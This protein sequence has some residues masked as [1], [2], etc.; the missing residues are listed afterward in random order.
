MCVLWLHGCCGELECGPVNQVNHTS[1]VAVVTPTDR[2][3]SVRNCCLIELFV[4]LC[5]LSLCP[6]DI[7]VGVHRLYVKETRAR[8]QITFEENGSLNNFPPSDCLFINQLRQLLINIPDLQHISMTWI[9]TSFSTVEW[10]NK[11]CVAYCS[12]LADRRFKMPE[13]KFFKKYLRG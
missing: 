5:A 6:F 10:L 13:Q 1:W 3:K 11:T 2:P 7:S 4:A 12:R 9:Q 8:K